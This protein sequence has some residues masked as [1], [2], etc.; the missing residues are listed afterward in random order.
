MSKLTPFFDSSYLCKHLF[1]NNNK[2]KTLLIRVISFRSVIPKPDGLRALGVKN[3]PRD[4][5]AR[6]SD[7]KNVSDFLKLS[8]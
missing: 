1:L 4:L 3:T 8:L 6:I 7:V 2:N 5:V